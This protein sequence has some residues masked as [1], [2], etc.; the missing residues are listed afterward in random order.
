MTLQ[1]LLGIS[2][3]AVAPER[4]QVARMLAAVE[5]NLADAQ[6]AGLSSESRFD[7]S[8]KAIM[9]DSTM[10]EC[11]NSATALCTHVSAWLHANKPELL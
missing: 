6:L 4:T 7:V 3:D 2:L 10:N 11:V 8:Y 5:R 9:Q 1:N